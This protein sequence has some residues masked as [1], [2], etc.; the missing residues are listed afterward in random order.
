MYGSE[1]CQVRVRVK[2]EIEAQWWSRTFDGLLISHEPD[3]TTL[4]SGDLPDQSAMHGVLAAVRD[5]GLPIVSVETTDDSGGGTTSRATPLRILIAGAGGLV[6]SAVAKLLAPDHEIVRLVRRTAGPGEI[7]WDPDA[8]TIDKARLDGFDAVVNMA[9]APWSGR[10]T[11][12]WKRRMR[13][14]RVGSYRLLAEALAGVSS[15]PDV[16][17]CASGMG[18]YAPAGDAVITEESLLADDFL[19]RLQQDGEAA[20]L[21]AADAGIRVVHLRLPMVL[22]GTALET[23]ATHNHRLGNGQQW[24]PWVARSE[25]PRIVEHVLASREI[26]GAVNV[27]S[28][29]ALRNSEMVYTASRVTGRKPG[30]PIPAFVLRGLLGGEM[31]TSLMLAS[32][33]ISPAR[34]LETGFVFQ[35]PDFEIA[36]R[37]ELTEAGLARVSP[38]G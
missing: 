23:L 32:R 2:G 31:V 13:A 34:L 30:R 18:I 25:V 4:L 24:S 33:R 14:N 8:G 22:G 11:K 9:T 20:T 3:G 12:E 10:W 38:V 28:P 37:H 6:G 35:T 7:A 1:T 17:V 29:R 21:A 19:G 16:L 5:L 15:R 36:L 27:A 26:T